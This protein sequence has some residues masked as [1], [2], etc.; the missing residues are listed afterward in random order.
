VIIVIVLLV[1]GGAVGGYL[2]WAG[3]RHRADSDNPRA[4]S[5]P[6]TVVE[7]KVVPVPPAKN[8][9]APTSAPAVATPLSDPGRKKVEAAP[10]KSTARV[11]SAAK[12]AA[13]APS[14]ARPAAKSKPLKPAPKAAARPATKTVK[15]T[16][17]RKAPVKKAAVKKAPVRTEKAAAAVAKPLIVKKTPAPAS[18]RY[19]VHAG[20]FQNIEKA[21]GQAA[22]FR[23]AGFKKAHVVKVDLKAKGVWYRILIPAGATQADAVKVRLEFNHKFAG[24]PSRII[25]LGK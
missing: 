25:K 22:R 18:A 4:T 3:Q 13:A 5:L 2:Y 24:E 1:I 20:S 12:K 17:S 11:D 14:A 6:T 19:A 10:E 21:K 7:E 16:P 15:K 8:P 9:P 23:K